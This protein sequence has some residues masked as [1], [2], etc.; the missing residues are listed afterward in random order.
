MWQVLH[1]IPVVIML[2]IAHLTPTW[3]K[4]QTLP[5]VQHAQMEVQQMQPEDLHH[6]VSVQVGS[7][8]NF[9]IWIFLIS[10]LIYV[11]LL[12]HVVAI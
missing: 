9:N 4:Q 8:T 10:M 1:R 6:V 11:I 7:F 5:S 2:V 3:M 12:I